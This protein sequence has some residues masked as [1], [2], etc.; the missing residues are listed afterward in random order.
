MYFSCSLN[1]YKKLA[2][3]RRIATLPSSIIFFK[4]VSFS[5][6]RGVRNIIC[7]I[8]MVCSPPPASAKSFDHPVV[9]P[10]KAASEVDINDNTNAVRDANRRPC[11]TGTVRTL[12]K[13]S[14]LVSRIS[15]RSSRAIKPQKSEPVKA[16]NL[17]SCNTFMKSPEDDEDIIAAAVYDVKGE[18]AIIPAH[19][20]FFNHVMG[21]KCC[22]YQNVS[23]EP[24]TTAN[25]AGIPGT[26]ARLTKSV[27]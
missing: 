20:T 5:Q 21:F 1:C 27:A 26:N 17:V 22:V 18:S 8:R 6:P 9:P 3:N 4:R 2:N 12:C 19:T 25:R 11:L 23:K 15:I 24:V 14:S 7:A 16:H 10:A 13:K